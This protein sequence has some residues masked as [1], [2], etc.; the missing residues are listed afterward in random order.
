VWGKSFTGQGKLTSVAI[1]SRD[2]VIV[3]GFSEQFGSY[4]LDLGGGYLM[5]DAVVG[6]LTASGNHVWSKAWDSE[7]NAYGIHAI[8]V[9]PGDLIAAT[10]ANDLGSD[11]L[12]AWVLHLAADGTETWIKTFG[13]PD[14]QVGRDVGFDT[15]GNVFVAATF[16]STIDFGGGAFTATD[17]SLGVAKLDSAGNHVFS[18]QIAPLHGCCLGSAIA[19]DPSG[20]LYVTGTAK[21]TGS[22]IDMGGVTAQVDSTNLFIGKLDAQG[23]GVWLVAGDATYSYGHAVAVGLSGGPR[24]TGH[25]RDTLDL[26]AGP[27][28]SVAQS[29]IFVAA[30]D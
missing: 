25:F 9:G 21:E 6:K 18:R 11:A 30:F 5:D 8:A 28:T 16:D 26:G 12:N 7:T 3:G 24:I 10:G 27:M 22:V 2:D 23:Q 1:D 4:Q 29:D 20:A 13:G 19:V 14:W 17:R 15:S